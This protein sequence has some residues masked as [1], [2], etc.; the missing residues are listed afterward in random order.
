MRRR[1]AVV[2]G[3][4]VLALPACGGD[5]DEPELW[6][7]PPRAAEDGSVAVE[8]FNDAIEG[9]NPD[10]ARAPLLAAAAFL[11]EEDRTSVEGPTISII[12]ERPEREDERTVVVTEDGL[13][14]DSVQAARYVLRFRRGENERW[15]L[16]SAEWSQ[17]CRPG[18]GHQDFAPELC[19]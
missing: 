12:E 8:D 14:D 13:L 9:R 16:V 15:Q 17:R 2:L 1:A 7:G 6:P 4:A 18:R 5:D 11:G 10:W 3:V 19:T